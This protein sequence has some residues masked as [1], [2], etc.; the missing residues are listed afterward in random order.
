MKT[1]IE[2]FTGETEAVTKSKSVIEECTRETEVVAK[3]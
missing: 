1:V 3:V 2:E